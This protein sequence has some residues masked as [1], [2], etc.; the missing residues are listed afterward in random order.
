MRR[1]GPER[2]AE[3]S[4]SIRV[5]ARETRRLVKLIGFYDAECAA[6]VGVTA[7]AR[8]AGVFNPHHEGI[9]E[10]A[11]GIRSIVAMGHRGTRFEVRE[12]AASL[13][14]RGTPK[15]FDGRDV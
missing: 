7:A 1:F 5:R 13:V 15:R 6:T 2:V 8:K 9:T 10:R 3:A 12:R 4:Q 11:R 14:A